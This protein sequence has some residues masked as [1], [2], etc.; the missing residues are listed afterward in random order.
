MVNSA[1]IVGL[2]GIPRR[3]AYT[4]AKGGVIA[5]TRSMAVEF[6]AHGIRVNCL[7]PGAVMTD[8]VRAFFAREPHLK[9]QMEGYLLGV[10]E[11]ADVAQAALFLACDESRRTTGQ[12]I[13][14]DSGI[15]IS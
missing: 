13:A 2:M 3:D 9:K 10:V 14:V 5:L 6:A 8:R 11:M 12:M 7:V 4:A 1:S 15:L